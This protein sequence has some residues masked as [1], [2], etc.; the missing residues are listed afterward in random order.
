MSSRLS[1]QFYSRD[2]VIL[3]RD[4]LGK[5]L[6]RRFG[7]REMRYRITETEAYSGAGDKA[8]HASKGMTSR[9]RIMFGE[10]GKVYVY[11]IYGM[12]WMLNIVAGEKEDASAVLIR[13]IEGISGPGRVGKALELNKSFYGEDLAESSRIWI[14]DAPATSNYSASP[15]VGIGYAGEPWISMPWRFMISPSD[16]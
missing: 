12:Y 4:L 16:R 11:L 2:V 13:G 3:A 7:D 9:T 14:E 1:P 6:V 10:G 8:C 5:V 15:R